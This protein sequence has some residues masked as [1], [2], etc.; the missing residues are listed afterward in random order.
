MQFVVA[1]GKGIGKVASFV[2]WVKYSWTSV[3]LRIIILPHENYLL[4]GTFL[5]LIVT[6]SCDRNQH[7]QR[8]E[9]NYNNTVQ[10]KIARREIES[11]LP[12]S[13]RYI[14]QLLVQYNSENPIC[15]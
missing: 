4:Y 14:I 13:F 5:S 2:S 10:M 6:N 7:N 9:N 15:I 1:A 11:Q 8:I 3:Q 12:W